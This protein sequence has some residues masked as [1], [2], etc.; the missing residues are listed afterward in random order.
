MIVGVPKE[1]KDGEFRVEITPANVR[2]LV[3]NSHNVIVETNAG[4]AGCFTDEDY[5]KAGVEISSNMEEV[6]AKAELIV[7]VKEILPKEFDLLKENHI[8]MTYIH[9]ANRLPETKAFLDNKVVA[10]A[11]EDLEDENGES[12]LLYQ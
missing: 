11:Y 7:K 2:R 4:V 8:I 5:K 12:I 3:D 6:Y 1:I 10:F 9:S